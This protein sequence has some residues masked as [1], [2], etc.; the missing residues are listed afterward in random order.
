MKL[1]TIFEMVCMMQLKKQERK[2]KMK[3]R[4]IFKIQELLDERK[5]PY[6]MDE[7]LEEERYCQSKETKI[8]YGDMHITHFIRVFMKNQNSMKKE[9]LEEMQYTLNQMYEDLQTLKKDNE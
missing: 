2:N 9:R 4:T 3:L 8:K 6:D 5:T 7:F 1:R